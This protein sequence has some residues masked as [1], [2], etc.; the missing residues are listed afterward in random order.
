MRENE[1]ASRTNSLSSDAVLDRNN[2]PVTNKNRSCKN[3]R[4][5]REA[6]VIY[7]PLSQKKIPKSRGP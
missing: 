1:T 2:F 3:G 6:P 7:S 5:S 4:R